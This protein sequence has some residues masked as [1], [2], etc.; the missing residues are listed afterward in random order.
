M[1]KLKVLTCFLPEDDDEDALFRIRVPNPRARIT[2]TGAAPKVFV[3]LN[4]RLSVWIESDAKRN[5]YC[6]LREPL[7]HDQSSSKFVSD[8]G[9]TA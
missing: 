5:P 1:R 8:E 6:T 4:F 3:S 7:Q 2:A 9:V